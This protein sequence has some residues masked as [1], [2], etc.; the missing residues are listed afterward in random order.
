MALLAVVLCV[1]FTACSK[2]DDGGAT[3]L[4]G[5][6]WKIIESD[7]GFPEGALITFMKDGTIVMTP[8]YDIRI[9]YSQSG[10]NLTV[11]IPDDDGQI[12]GNF[13]INGKTA[14]YKY[15]WY[16]LNGK[17]EGDPYEYMTLQKQ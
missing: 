11:V 5:T 14:T 2:D 7:G 10:S 9:T 3:D 6:T 4:K 12:K 8:H 15:K 13:S 16:D 17:D 1:N